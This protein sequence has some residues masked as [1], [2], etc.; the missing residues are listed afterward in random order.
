MIQS[1]KKFAVN[2][3]DG[4]KISERHLIAHDDFLLDAIRDANSL[5]CTHY[6]YGLLPIVIETEVNGVK[7]ALFEVQ[8]SATNDVTVVVKT[9]CALTAAGYRIELKHF[10]TNIR[11]LMKASDDNNVYKDAVYYISISCNPFKH[12]PF[13]DVDPDETP[14]RHPFTKSKFSIEL[15]TKDMLKPGSLGGN[16]V[17]VGKVDVVGGNVKADDQFI[18]PCTSVLSHPIL[19]T[20]YDS[21]NNSMAI[22]QQSAL[23]I[24]Q[25][26]VKTQQNNTLA[27]NVKSLCETLKDHFAQVYFNFRNIIPEQPPIYM[28][29][30]FSSMALRLYNSTQVLATGELEEMLNYSFEWSEIAPHTLLNQLSVVA[31]LNYDHNNCAEHL[32]E[33]RKLLTDLEVIFNKLSSLDYIGQ[34][35]DNIIIKETDITPTVKGTGGW[36]LLD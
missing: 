33:I 16:Y 18:P 4:M 32:S 34:R 12:V 31:E 10:N 17:V 26:I 20:Y 6:N 36:S 35:K 3:T 25:K 8:N 1:I 7:S 24:I 23:V 29:E 9:C 21:L 22:L 13:G 14:P 30:V 15:L 11:S 19:R 28:I 5:R 2:W 27:A